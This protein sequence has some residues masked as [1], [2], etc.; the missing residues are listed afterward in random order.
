MIIESLI[1]VALGIKLLP[2]H[3]KH[4]EKSERE[5]LRQKDRDDFKRQSRDN[6]EWLDEQNR[7][8]KDFAKK[9]R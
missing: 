8:I 1:L 6:R 4:N 2:A 5:K 9:K 3:T 7:I